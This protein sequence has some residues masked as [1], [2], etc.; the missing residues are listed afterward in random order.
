MESV[1]KLTRSRLGRQTLHF[2]IGKFIISISL[3]FIL[4]ATCLTIGGLEVITLGYLPLFSQARYVVWTTYKAKL[5]SICHPVVWWVFSAFGNVLIFA[6]SFCVFLFYLVTIP[7]VWVFVNFSALVTFG[8]V[9]FTKGFKYSFRAR[10]ARLFSYYLHPKGKHPE[11]P[12]LNW[13]MGFLLVMV[14]TCI[15]LRNRQWVRG[16]SF[17]TGIDDYMVSLPDWSWYV[18]LRGYD[19]ETDVWFDADEVARASPLA[20]MQEKVDKTA[21]SVLQVSDLGVSAMKNI[22]KLSTKVSNTC[23]AIDVQFRKIG[24]LLKKVDKLEEWAV[25]EENFDFQ[26]YVEDVA[27]VDSAQGGA[28]PS[29]MRVLDPIPEVVKER[30]RVQS[31]A[32]ELVED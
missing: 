20:S 19:A 31:M 17:L 28:G 23:Y 10:R 13:Y 1:R 12:A 30:E 15:R 22:K 5:R 27:E 29:T 2:K 25:A 32:G 9:G 24:T 3:V 26:P 7:F 8:Y 18:I 6:M 4:L 11:L 16:K 14:P 21:A